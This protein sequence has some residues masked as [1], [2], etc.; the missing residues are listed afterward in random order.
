MANSGE[1]TF[2]R[3]LVNVI[4]K[5]IFYGLKKI[6]FNHVTYFALTFAAQMIVLEYFEDYQRLE[7]ML[8]FFLYK[9]LP[10]YVIKFLNLEFYNLFERFSDNNQNNLASNTKSMNNQKMLK[11]IDYRVKSN[12]D[13]FSILKMINLCICELINQITFCRS[14]LTQELI[15]LMVIEPARE[16]SAPSKEDLRQRYFKI[17]LIRNVDFMNS[18]LKVHQNR[19]QKIQI[20]QYN[21]LNIIKKYLLSN[22]YFFFE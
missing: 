15:N 9:F 2:H 5:L 7:S 12:L 14:E 19:G 22:Y 20:V 4:Y 11:I 3:M 21:N 17:E 1:K 8:V 18:L 13:L 10:F 6:N 16:E